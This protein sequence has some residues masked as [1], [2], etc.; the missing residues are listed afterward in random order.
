MTKP[1]RFLAYYLT[2]A[3]ALACFML[4]WHE[5]WAGFW[6]VLVGAAYIYLDRFEKKE[7]K[8]G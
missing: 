8:N 7:D 1:R 4:V 2:F 6:S 3:A 5:D